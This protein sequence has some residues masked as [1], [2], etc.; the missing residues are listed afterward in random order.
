MKKLQ[1][2][3]YMYASSRL[4]ALERRLI[5]RERLDA[6]VECH[7]VREVMARLDEYGVMPTEGAET[8]SAAERER[9]L[10]ALLAE[11]HAEVEAAVP[12]PA[13]FRAYRYP[14]DC[15]NLKAA[16]KCALRGIPTDGLLVDLGTVPASRVEAILREDRGLEAFPPAMAVAV[17]EAREAYAATGDPGRIDAVLDR[18]CYADMLAVL[19]AAGD[20]TLTGWLRA[21][22]D[23]VNIRICLRLLRM[24]RGDVGAAVLR[25]SLLSGGT[26]DASF[27]TTAYAAGEAGLWA[28]LAPTAYASLARSEG[29]APTLGAV[30]KAADDLWMGMVRDGARVAFGAPIA[31]G[32]LIGWEWAVRNI[33]IVLSAKE[34]GVSQ[35]ALRERLRV[36]Y[37]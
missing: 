6:L 5:G 20:E 23:L 2:T 32:Y 22:I 37:A 18:A 11:A 14:Y 12:D 4:R 27:M 28:A 8:L 21:K 30:E 15:H 19:T 1:P 7:T 36:S 9:M 13:P 26:L 34:A 24:E 3:E 33:R 16:V 25:E 10:T 31:A 35:E 17:R 29:D